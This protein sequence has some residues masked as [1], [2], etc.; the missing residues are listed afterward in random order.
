[1]GFN[2]SILGFV[3]RPPSTKSR[4]ERSGSSV[5]LRITRHVTRCRALCK[6]QSKQ[7]RVAG[8]GAGGAAAGAAEQAVCVK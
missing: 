2:K 3:E 7:M 6:K 1:M 4:V 5:L 8:C